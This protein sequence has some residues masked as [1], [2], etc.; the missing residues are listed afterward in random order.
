MNWKTMVKKYRVEIIIEMVIVIF[1]LICGIVG[2]LNF[3]SVLSEG[4]FVAAALSVP[5]AITQFLISKNKSDDEFYYA[6][7]ERMFQLPDFDKEKFEDDSFVKLKL[8][9]LQRIYES[10]MNEISDDK[11]KRDFEAA[12]ITT[13]F[14]I[15]TK[16]MDFKVEQIFLNTDELEQDCSSQVSLN[17]SA[18]LEKFKK[19][20]SYIDDRLNKDVEFREMLQRLEYPKETG[21]NNYVD[22]ESRVVDKELQTIFKNVVWKRIV[23]WDNKDK[24]VNFDNNVFLN[25]KFRNWE[26][27]GVFDNSIFINPVF[28]YSKMTDGE[29]KRMRNNLELNHYNDTSYVSKNKLNNI[30]INPI[31]IINDKRV[32]LYSRE[33]DS[34]EEIEAYIEQIDLTDRSDLRDKYMKKN[35]GIVKISK[36]Y[37]MCPTAQLE[38]WFS[39]NRDYWQRFN[40][41]SYM[42]HFYF[43]VAGE[44]GS[45][46]ICFDKINLQKIISMKENSGSYERF[47]FYFRFKQSKNG[48][49][50][51]CDSKV[52]D[53]DSIKIRSNNVEV[54][55][56]K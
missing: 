22:T 9:Q 21:Q 32:P 38:S 51:L 41:N 45:I 20:I 30:M 7:L 26:D 54:V 8:I 19:Y 53:D 12:T 16:G 40:E 15:I 2:L 37:N 11:S 33:G 31:V 28:Y 48:N 23:S 56:G 17:S 25:V 13:Y 39:F 34:E 43:I 5:I 52:K 42:K 44:N 55:N 47:D 27:I 10:A 50:N 49:W 36:V 18:Y 14:K 29:A 35:D 46:A 6:S 1:L 3:H 4:T 24:N